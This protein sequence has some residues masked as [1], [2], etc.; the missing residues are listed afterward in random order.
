MD[1]EISEKLKYLFWKVREF[2]FI[3]SVGTLISLFSCHKVMQQL[4]RLQLTQAMLHHPCVTAELL[5]NQFSCH[6]R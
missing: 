1:P 2:Y 6:F 4:T 3:R 5:V